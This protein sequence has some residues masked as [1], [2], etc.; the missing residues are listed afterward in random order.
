MS[1]LRITAGPFEFRARWEREAAPNTCAAFERLLPFRNKIIHVRWS[2]ESAWIPLGDMSTWMILLRNG[3][4][5]SNAAQVFGAASRSQRARN[6]NG[7]AVILRSLIRSSLLGDEQPAGCL[8]TRCGR[9]AACGRR[10]RRSRR[11][12]N[13]LAR[14]RSR[15]SPRGAR[16][17]PRPAR[18]RRRRR[19]PGAPCRAAGSAGPAPPVTRSASRSSG[20]PRRSPSP[21][22]SASVVCAP[23]IPPQAASNPPSFMAGGQGEWSE[24]DERHPPRELR[25]QRLGVGRATAART[26]RA[27]RAAPCRRR[28]ARGSA[29]RSRRWRRRRAPAPRP[30]RDARGR[31]RRARRAA[32]SRLLR[33]LERALDRGE[34]GAPAAASGPL[35]AS[36][37]SRGA[38]SPT[39]ARRA[40]RPAGRARRRAPCRRRAPRR[41][42]PGSPRSPCRT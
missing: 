34:L 7:P 42:P 39:G 22:S 21:S 32:S 12:A 6:S 15:S 30:P 9:A 20:T 18:G 36:S 35:A 11:P 37:P 4:S 16:R 2:G 10:G 25:P 1:D 29:G 24:R 17:R 8:R 5:R 31:S 23:A 38:R 26:W 33:Q 27:S 14:W 28:A 13:G 3:S 40:R 41:R 19:P